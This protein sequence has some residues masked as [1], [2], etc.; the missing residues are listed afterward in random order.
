M[1]ETVLDKDPAS[2]PLAA[3]DVAYV[4]QGTGLDRDRKVT[5]AEVLNGSLLNANLPDVTPT[6]PAR[7]GGKIPVRNTT[8]PSSEFATTSQ[9]V[10]SGLVSVTR[11][12]TR[13][14]TT[15]GY[16]PFLIDGGGG[17]PTVKMVSAKYFLANGTKVILFGT[18]TPAEDFE[19]EEYTIQ[20]EDGNLHIIV[21]A[22]M[23]ATDPI[24]NGEI[25]PGSSISIINNGVTKYPDA[26][27]PALEY[28]RVQTPDMGAGYIQ[29]AN[30]YTSAYMAFDGALTGYWTLF[31]GSAPSNMA[32]TNPALSL[33]SISELNAIAT[34]DADL[35]VTFPLAASKKV[36]KADKGGFQCYG[37]I[38]FQLPQQGDPTATLTDNEIMKLYHN[39]SGKL[40]L[41]RGRDSGGVDRKRQQ[42]DDATETTALF[43]EAAIGVSPASPGHWAS[44]LSLNGSANFPRY[45]FPTDS[46]LREATVRLES[47]VNDA[48][49]TTTCTLVC[50]I[51]DADDT[52]IGTYSSSS[53]DIT[54]ELSLVDKNF[55]VDFGGVSALA[56]YSM[57]L[58]LDVTA[59]TGTGPFA[60]AQN[61]TVA[62]RH[63]RA[64]IT[65]F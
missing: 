41:D 2:L 32:V 11:D 49:D 4:I 21:L 25:R 37:P 14:T 17:T 47:I 19:T 36:I 52:L 59:Q 43:M 24:I 39:T 7:W 10:S 57:R 34:R 50:G 9:V 27:N 30:G 60:S 13:P 29:C 55:T 38:G 40:M 44:A 54:G 56:G 20:P 58:Y 65:G 1:P 5:I 16:M 45:P 23:G 63:A 3:T 51:Y 35:V 61:T 53:F 46:L 62:L 12:S 28:C 31:F 64:L 6:D 18:N 26:T 22:S 48:G 8:G 15:V 42:L 33:A